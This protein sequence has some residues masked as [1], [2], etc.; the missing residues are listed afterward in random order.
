MDDWTK[1]LLSSFTALAVL[2]IGQALIRFVLE[3]IQ[4]Y[5]KLTG[6]IA[7]SLIYFNN[8]APVDLSPAPPDLD[9]AAVKARCDEASDTFRKLAARLH[10]QLSAMPFFGLWSLLGWLPAKRDALA[11]HSALIALSN[12]QHHMSDEDTRQEARARVLRLLRIQGI[13]NSSLPPHH[14]WWAFW[15]A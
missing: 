9:R 11:A 13:V 2:L 4:E 14:P 10:V 5:H 12:S 15:R 7:H 6:E 3:P 1:I 8:V